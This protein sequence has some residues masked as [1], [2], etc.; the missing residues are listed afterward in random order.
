MNLVCYAPPIPLVWLPVDVNVWPPG[1]MRVGL[2][3]LAANFY[4]K[5]ETPDGRDFKTHLGQTTSIECFI[6]L[7][8]RRILT[9]AE[10]DGGK[11]R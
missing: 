8:G 7:L 11:K 10:S 9:E 1:N 6:L 2:T 5:S 4:A 3:L